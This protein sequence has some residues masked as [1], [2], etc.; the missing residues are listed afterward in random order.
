[1]QQ[2]VT[3]VAKMELVCTNTGVANKYVVTHRF[4]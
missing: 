4:L 2:S 3:K 1:M